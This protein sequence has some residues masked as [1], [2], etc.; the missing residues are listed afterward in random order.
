M[1][2]V[3]ILYLN[4]FNKILHKLDKLSN[5]WVE[6]INHENITDLKSGIISHFF[7]IY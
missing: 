7:H 6:F 4:R 3:F 1:H 2:F 5:I